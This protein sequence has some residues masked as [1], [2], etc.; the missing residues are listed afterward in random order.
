MLRL[1]YPEATPLKVLLFLIVLVACFFGAPV[2]TSGEMLYSIAPA[3]AAAIMAAPGLVKT[4]GAIYDRF[5]DPTK[6]KERDIKASGLADILK[7]K[8][9]GLGRGKQEGMAAS[10]Q[11]MVLG[12]TKKIE[13][14]L[15]RGTVGGQKGGGNVFKKLGE[16]FKGRGAASASIL[17]SIAK[18]DQ[19]AKEADKADAY[20][21]A[22]M[23]AETGIS[24]ITGA[25]GEGI[26]SGMGAY[27]AGAELQEKEA[28][29]K[30]YAKA[31]AEKI[32]LAREQAGLPPVT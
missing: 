14:D 12:Q 24:G 19:A 3:A 16:L 13:A 25:I 27:Q 30:A 10:G 32:K 20:R 9:K 8:W 6:K 1:M 29:R 23:P 21:R 5:F 31:E 22:G 7:G 4:G 28:L 17:S 2:E 15:R 26:T 18:A 11:R